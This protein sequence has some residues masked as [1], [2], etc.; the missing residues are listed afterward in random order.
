MSSSLIRTKWPEDTFG[1]LHEFKANL[2]VLFFT[3]FLNL[4][5]VILLLHRN[6]EGGLLLG[7]L[8]LGSFLGSWWTIA[9]PTNPFRKTLFS[10]WPLKDLDDSA[11]RILS[12]LGSFK[13]RMFIVLI[14]LGISALILLIALVD[15]YFL[16]PDSAVTWGLDNPYIFAGVLIATCFYVFP[17][18][19]TQEL[20]LHVWIAKNFNQVLSDYHPWH[21][22]KSF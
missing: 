7:T 13:A 21:T 19:V 16:R 20:V 22:N 1:Q 10:P 18:H 12:F 11:L 6:P 14:A 15:W 17:V 5:I 9:K 3:C 2:W 4:G 8:L